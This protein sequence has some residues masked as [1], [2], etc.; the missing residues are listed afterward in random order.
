MSSQ[1]SYELD[2]RQIRILLQD[3]EI[4]YN[5]ALWH[6]FDELVT[7]RSKSS[8]NISNYIPKI[9]FSISRSIIVPVLFIIFIGGLSAMLFSFV[10]FKKKQSIEKEIPFVAKS[11]KIKDPVIVHK[12][13]V[14]AKPAITI[15][16]KTNSVVVTNSIGATPTPEIKKAEPVK[17]AEIK[18][19][20]KEK[21]TPVIEA[22]KEAT[23]NIVKKKGKKKLKPQELPIINTST[24]LNEGFTEPELE[25]DLK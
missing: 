24:N 1:F 17:V 5:E 10:D 18:L 3:A 25:L 12:Q 2:E 11:D 16:A 13:V 19:K 23:V 6:K 15:V 21:I 20:E 4:D 14:K 8:S 22:K 9:N 7:I